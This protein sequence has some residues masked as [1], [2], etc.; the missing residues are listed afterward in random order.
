M[1][2]EQ[3]QGREADNRSDLF[4]FGCVFYELLSGRRAFDGSSAASVIAAILEREPSP[5]D[6]GPPLDRVIRACLAK[7]PEQRFQTALDL[8]RALD[9]AS[10]HQ[11]AVKRRFA[12]VWVAVAALALGLVGGWVVSQLSRASPGGH[13]VRLQLAPPD[14]GQ[15]LRLRSF[16]GWPHFGL[17]S[18]RQ[19]KKR[20]LAPAAG[21]HGRAALAGHGGRPLSIL[22]TGRKIHRLLC[23]EQTVA[24]KCSRG[25]AEC[26][27]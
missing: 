8:K 16:P 26:H 17:W 21:R 24:H 2:P 13:A 6:V 7:D 25:P 27:L 4:A 18:C 22:V 5:I 20:T 11:P 14:G 3:L 10:D 12:W 1:S 23:C 15:S 9:W 19:R